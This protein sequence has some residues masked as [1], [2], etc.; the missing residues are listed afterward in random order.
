MEEYTKVDVNLYVKEGLEKGLLT[1]L[2]AEKFAKIIAK[3]SKGGETVISYSVDKDGNPII[4]K[5]AITKEGDYIATKASEDGKEVLD[6]HNNLNQWIIDEETFNKKYEMKKGNVFKPK[7]SK[8][9]FVE[10][11][12]PII[13]NQ[14]GSDMKIDAGGYINITN[15]EDMYGISK[16]DFEDTYKVVSKKQKKELN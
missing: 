6:Q 13:L 12:N 4:E 14:W 16:R 1:P 5:E 15:A 11:P 8:Q 7:G 10:I 2:Q 3:Q 9:L